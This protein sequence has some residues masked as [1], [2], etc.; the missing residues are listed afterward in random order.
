MNACLGVGIALDA[1]GLA[2]TLARAG[3]GLG[4]LAAHRQPAQMADA[5][6][7]L[8]GLQT[9]EVQ[10][11]FTPQIA[12]GHIFA[13]LNGMDDLRQLLFVQVLGAEGRIDVG[14]GQDFLRID[15][16]DAVDVTQR[17][18]DAFAGGNIDSQNAWHSWLLTLTLFVAR[19]GTD[20]AN[21]TSAP[22]NFAV[23]AEP[24]Y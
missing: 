15:R 23:L 19:V 3:V 20:N 5:A 21:D 6:I 10:T 9:L 4:A 18:F 1:D 16:P 12:F 8:D 7:T 11:D 17:D 14:L 13:V 24:F 2:R 22:H